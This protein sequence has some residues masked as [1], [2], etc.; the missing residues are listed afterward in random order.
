MAKRK[1][2]RKPVPRR[3]WLKERREALKLSQYALSVS[4]GVDDSTV[5]RWEAGETQPSGGNLVALADALEMPPQVLRVRLS[6]ER[7]RTDVEVAARRTAERLPLLGGVRDGFARTVGGS[8]VALGWLAW[9][10][11]R[12]EAPAVHE[13]DVPMTLLAVLLEHAHVERDATGL[14]SFIDPAH[15]EAAIAQHVFDDIAVGSDLL[16]ATAQTSHACDFRIAQLLAHEELLKG[17][18]AEWMASGHSAVL[19]VNAAGVLAKT[20][21]DPWCD[22]VLAG[23]QA[24][25]AVR[26]LYITAVA[27]RVLGLPWGQAAQWADGAVDGTSMPLSCGTGEE[28]QVA[29]LA[30]AQELGNQRDAGARYCAAL[31]LRSVPGAPPAK[32]LEGVRAAV[33]QEACLENLRVFAGLLGAWAGR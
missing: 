11:W 13:S 1:Q 22:R 16:L 31:L 10:L 20:G 17:C 33:E 3:T 2:G 26:R 18:L 12:T 23:L 14:L 8:A 9:R 25:E 21:A 24:D 6:A 27:S 32:A 30:L 29:Q 4:I 5:E 19:R 28:R 15:L 7:E